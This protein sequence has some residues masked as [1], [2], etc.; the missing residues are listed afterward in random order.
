MSGRFCPGSYRAS[1]RAKLRIYAVSKRVALCGKSP[2]SRTAGVR[3]VVRSHEGSRRAKMVG[4][5]YCGHIWNCPT[6]AARLRTAR[7]AKIARVVDAAPEGWRLMS[8]T[9]RH[10]AADDPAKLMQGLSRAWARMRAGRAGQQR[11]HGDVIRSWPSPKYKGGEPQFYKA[12]GRFHGAQKVQWNDEREGLVLAYVRTWDV[13][14]GVHGF[15]PHVHVLLRFKPG[16]DV[17]AWT[18]AW[19]ADWI[20]AVRSELGPT[21]TPSLDIG[22]HMSARGAGKTYVAK[23]GLELA[24]YDAHRSSRGAFEVSAAHSKRAQGRSR[25]PWQLAADVAKEGRGIDVYHWTRYQ[26]AVRGRRCIEWSRDAKDLESELFDGTAMRQDDGESAP[27]NTLHLWPEEWD[28]V[29]AYER[30][31]PPA[32]FDLLKT[33]ESEGLRGVETWMANATRVTRGRQPKSVDEDNEARSLLT[34]APF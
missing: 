26:E 21:H 31:R 6:C 34:D 2:V 25:S 20:R 30:F 19:R 3:I 33:A 29:R 7:G 28:M 27:E 13:T 4:V 8:L 24:D 17:D 23:M 32:L 15:H 18:D 12:G 16:V 10:S 1:L 5:R 11:F 9:I 22:T 14:Q